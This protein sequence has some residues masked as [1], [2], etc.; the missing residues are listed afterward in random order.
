MSR[1]RTWLL[2]SASGILAAVAGFFAS[3]VI[4]SVFQAPTETVT[5][6]IPT[7]TGAQGPQGDPGPAGPKGDPGSPGAESCPTG[8]T[9]KAVKFNAP[10]GQTTIWTCVAG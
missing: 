5:V 4:G 8:S 9:F 3:G 7:G 2:L 6:N 10:G 1:W